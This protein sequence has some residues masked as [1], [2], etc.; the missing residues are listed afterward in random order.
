MSTKSRTR[1][2]RTSLRKAA[3]GGAALSIAA[4]TVIAGAGV[5]NA[6]ATLTFDR[7]AGPDRYDTSALTAKTFGASD[8]AILASG[9]AGSTVDALSSAYLAG[10]KKA[11][12]LLTQKDTTPKSVLD[13]LAAN[14]VKNIFV[15]GGASVISDA[16]I[17]TLTNAGYI[18]TRVSGA[19]R[20]GTSA[21]VIKAAGA[22]TGKTAL[23]A[24]GTVFP[25]ALGAGSLSY[26]ADVPLAITNPL[27]LSPQTLTALKAT[28]VTNVVIVGG[29][30]T[31]KPTVVGELVTAGFTVDPTS[32][33]GEDR[34]ETSTMLAA[35]EMTKFPQF[36]DGTGANVASGTPILDGVDA[37]GG[38]ARSGQEGRPLLITANTKNAGTIPAYL[39][40]N[41]SKLEKGTIFGGLGAVPPAVAEALTAAAKIPTATPGFNP[42]QI[43]VNGPN[44]ATLG[45]GTNPPNTAIAAE[46]LAIPITS[47]ETITF[48][49]TLLNGAK[50]IGGAPRAFVIVD[51]KVYN[52]VDGNVPGTDVTF[53]SAC[54][55]PVTG[56]PDTFDVSY[57]LTAGGT[58]TEAA[59]VL[60]NGFNPTQ[61]TAQ[62]KVS[63]FEVAGQKILFG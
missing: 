33:A 46:G 14:K 49:Y 6:T 40:K 13:Q 10:V 61:K 34:S 20:Y 29:P 9:V 63:D 7:I 1:V 27:T 58:V 12:V 45:D 3:V 16:Q 4:A 59:L 23:L 52:S 26:A 53:A 11:P 42:A 15:V 36:F 37:L 60:D 28:G 39:T 5:A 54:G 38:A 62:V 24:S 8:N 31:V 43:T 35:Y 55:T 21:A 22:P 41:S 2:A 56:M 47:T 48:R 44:S 51:G 30:G 50:C 19:D 25:D 17:G 57:S 32:L 18:V